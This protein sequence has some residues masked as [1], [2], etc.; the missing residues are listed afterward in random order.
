T[1]TGGR[2]LAHGEQMLQ[3][4]AGVTLHPKQDFGALEALVLR[5]ARQLSGCVLIFLAWDEPRRHLH[6]RLRSIGVPLLT[7][8]VRDQPRNPPPPPGVHE[9]RAGHAEESLSALA[10]ALP[11]VR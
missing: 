5:H 11:K 7:F 4:L 8:V 6:D 2:G 1:F 10:S 3:V 9:V